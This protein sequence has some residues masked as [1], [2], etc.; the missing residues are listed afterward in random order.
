M[1]WKS[2]ATYKQEPESGTIFEA[3]GIKGRVSIHKIHGCGDNWYMSCPDLRMSKVELG[4][5]D[6]NNAVA[7]AK[8]FIKKELENLQAAFMPFISDESENKIVRY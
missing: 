7:I 6:F 4:T 2:N 1:E 5:Q 3:K 8:S